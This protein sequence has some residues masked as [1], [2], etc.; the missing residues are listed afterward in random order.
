MA[1][2]RSVVK[3]EK[4]T[5]RAKA[6]LLFCVC[7]H[8]NDKAAAKRNVRVSSRL[9]AETDVLTERPE[10]AAGLT[11]PGHAHFWGKDHPAPPPAGS[12]EQLFSGKDSSD[13]VQVKS[14]ANNSGSL[15]GGARGRSLRPSPPPSSSSTSSSNSSSRPRL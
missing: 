10:A 4:K 12:Q 1:I 5:E 7:C 13:Q 15:V 14:S 6:R 11:V 8:G 2:N 3:K 9:E